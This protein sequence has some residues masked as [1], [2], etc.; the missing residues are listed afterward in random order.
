MPAHSDAVWA[1]VTREAR[2]EGP[3]LITC[4][5]CGENWKHVSRQRVYL[6][7]QKCKELPFDL[8]QTYQNGDAVIPHRTPKDPNAPPL[9]GR[10]GRAGRGG[11]RAAAGPSAGMDADGEGDADAVPDFGAMSL[12][13]GLNVPTPQRNGIKTWAEN[14]ND[15]DHREIDNLLADWFNDAGIRAQMVRYPFFF[16]STGTCV[17]AHWSCFELLSTSIMWAKGKHL[18]EIFS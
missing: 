18:E 5:Y 16:Y 13:P 11:G 3:P 2:E 4:I 10:G 12:P 7:L 14:I 15:N 8:Q 1:H 6:H 17:C 9:R